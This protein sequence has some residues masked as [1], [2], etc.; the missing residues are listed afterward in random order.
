MD[1]ILIY[2]THQE[3]EHEQHVCQVLQ[4]L[5]EFGLYCTAEKCRFAVLE[6]GFLGFLITPDV[7]GIE[8]GQISTIED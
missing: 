7:F 3:E 4:Q 5:K 1:D 2:L 6:V 8:S